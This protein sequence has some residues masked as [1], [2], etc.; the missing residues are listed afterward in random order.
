MPLPD[1]KTHMAEVH[2]LAK[3]VRETAIAT[4]LSPEQREAR[5][6]IGAIAPI[7]LAKSHDIIP[8]H[9]VLHMRE[10]HCTNCGALT[11][12][13]EFYALSYLKSRINQTRV[14]HLTR[15][16]RPLFNLPVERALIA[17]DKTPFCSECETISLDH[18]PPPPSP[19]L[20]YDLAE[21]RNKGAKAKTPKPETKP[22]TLEDI[23]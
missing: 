15:C 11:R 3:Q 10:C 14:R 13:S 22:T 8:H 17:R 21:P 5:D 9:Y 4:A 1:H 19:A 23:I 7:H 12:S 2:S 18:L 6:A 20:L 16:D